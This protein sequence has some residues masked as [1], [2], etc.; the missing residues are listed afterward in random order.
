[1][2][3]AKNQCI[4]P[5]ANWFAYGGFPTTG[6]P[7]LAWVV[8]QCSRYQMNNSF[9]D[10]VNNLTEYPATAASRSAANATISSD[11]YVWQGLYGTSFVFDTNSGYYILGCNSFDAFTSN[12][13]P[14]NALSVMPFICEA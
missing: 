2:G 13:K 4:A 3:F 12:A 1:M 10:I 6:S 9:A 14:I 7:N 11:T 5:G 8:A